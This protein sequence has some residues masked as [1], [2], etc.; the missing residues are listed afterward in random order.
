MSPRAPSLARLP[1]VAKHRSETLRIAILGTVVVVLAFTLS[2]PDKA[3]FWI[4]FA[5]AGIGLGPYFG[6]RQRG[7]LWARLVGVSVSAPLFFAL[8]VSSPG[9]GAFWVAL[10][11][12]VVVMLPI[13]AVS[14]H[15][16]TAK[17]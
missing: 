13:V 15:F 3:G 4:A 6:K 7:F 12:T 8:A 14:A 16:L 17:R 5:I 10:S 11:V 2:A 1:V 9:R